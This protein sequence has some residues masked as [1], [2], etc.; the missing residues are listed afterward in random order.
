VQ[1]MADL[2]HAGKCTE[3]QGKFRGGG[4]IRRSWIELNVK[5]R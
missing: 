4:P 5:N 3:T 2:T 1:Q